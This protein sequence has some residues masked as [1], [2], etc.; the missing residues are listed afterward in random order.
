MKIG[1]ITPVGPG[2]DEIYEICK[3]SIVNAWKQNNGP[4]TELE[5]IAMPDPDGQQGRSARRNDGIKLAKN[6]QCHWLFF[7]DADD[8]MS[9]SA[10][11]E[12]TP[13]LNKYDA[14]WGAICEMPYGQFEKLKIRENQ[15]KSTED[16]VDVLIKDPYHTLQMGHFVKTDIALEIGFDSSIHVGEDFKY[17]LQVCHKYKFIKCPK[18][19]FINQRGRHSTG[20]LSSDGQEWRSS[21]QNEIKRVVSE[22][23]VIAKVYLDDIESR[24]LITN[25]FD[26]IQAHHCQGIFF[27]QGELNALKKY[28][29][30]QKIIVEIGANIGNHAIFYAHHMNPLKIIPFEPNPDSVSLFRKNLQLNHIE[31]EVDERGIGIG[32]G[33]SNKRYSIVQEDLNNLGAAKLVESIGDTGSIEVKTFDEVIEGQQVDF[34]KIDVEGMEFDVLDGASGTISEHKPVLYVEVWNEGIPRLEKWLK[35]FNY[36]LVAHS[37]MIN[38]VNFLIGPRS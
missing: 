20:P 38:H 10:F 28:I 30:P 12:V 3:Q 15:L 11:M 32:L 5:I 33:S 6:N 9:P 29:G 35:K 24:F 22:R 25:P 21:V 27:E 14:I 17:Y 23:E 13:Y 31:A 16:V 4:F 26:I 37:K 18:I 34:I 1:I 36:Q 2:H 7:L 19:F 8:L